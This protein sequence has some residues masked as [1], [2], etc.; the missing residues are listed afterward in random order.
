MEP[1]SIPRTIDEEGGQHTFLPSVSWMGHNRPGVGDRVGRE[2]LSHFR[3][4]IESTNQS[5]QTT[6]EP[7]ETRPN[8]KE[9]RRKEVLAMLSEFCFLA[10]LISCPSSFYSEDFTYPL[11]SA[12][13]TTLFFCTP[14]TPRRHLLHSGELIY[15]HII[16][17]F[18]LPAS[19]SEHLEIKSCILFI[20]GTQ[21]IKYVFKRSWVSWENLGK[22][23]C[24]GGIIKEGCLSFFGLRQ[25]FWVWMLA[26]QVTGAHW[27]SR[28]TDFNFPNL[29]PRL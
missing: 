7:K 18:L 21:Q 1:L 6:A 23:T 14:W 2:I 11:P 22:R 12:H 15:L 4:N 3:G 19:D 13:L 9:R 29:F 25:W 26:L 16:F 20:S 5:S 24:V 27:C 8:H 28:I 10:S 17:C